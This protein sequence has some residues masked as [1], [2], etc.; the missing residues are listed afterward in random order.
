[1]GLTAFA[2]GMV[3][4]PR[5]KPHF[6]YPELSNNLN[7]AIRYLVEAGLNIEKVKTAIANDLKPAS[8]Y[9]SGVRIQGVVTVDGVTVKYSGTKLPNGKINIGTMQP[10]RK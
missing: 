3:G 10:P 7:H 9:K 4:I 5:P 1:M 6:G 8:S 2:H